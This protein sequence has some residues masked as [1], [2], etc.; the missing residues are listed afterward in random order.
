MLQ[1]T[2]STLVHELCLR[3]SERDHVFFAKG[4]DA[5][6]FFACKTILV[7]RCRDLHHPDFWLT[8]AN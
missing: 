8:S 2:G 6:I 7:L 3:V 1:E 4:L 5:L